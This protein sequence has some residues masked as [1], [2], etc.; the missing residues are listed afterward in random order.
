MAERI[1]FNLAVISSDVNTVLAST[2]PR[3]VVFSVSP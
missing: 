2:T 1:A 3:G